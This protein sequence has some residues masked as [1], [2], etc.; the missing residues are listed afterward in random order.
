MSYGVDAP[1]GLRPMQKRGA[2]AFDEATQYQISSGS[3][4]TFYK[5]DLVCVA[6]ATVTTANV[7]PGDLIPFTP[8]V[9]AG[10]FI[11][12]PPLASNIPVGVFMGCSYSVPASSNPTNLYQ[13][14]PVWIGG[15]PTYGN[16]PAVAYVIDDPDVIFNIQC[17]G[18]TAPVTNAPS[19]AVAMTAT[20]IGNLTTGQSG[21]YLNMTITPVSSPSF[22]TNDNSSI[23]F[24]LKIVGVVQVPG[25]VYGIPYL[26]LKVSLNSSGYKAGQVGV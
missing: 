9:L 20:G 4:Y 23:L 14:N 24:P 7:L 5:G 18:N 17:G 25:N 13:Q 1:W 21:T 22:L 12:I 26:N 15:T 8:F 11:T 19:G 3:P 16:Q 6:S 2:G 10:N